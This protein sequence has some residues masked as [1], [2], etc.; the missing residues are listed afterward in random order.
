MHAL[1]GSQEFYRLLDLYSLETYLFEKVSTQFSES[2]TMSSYD[3]F[4]IVIWKSNRAK[5]KIKN[6]LSAIGKTVDELMRAVGT[7]PEQVTK[8][9]L[10]LATPGIG[11]A[12]A[13]AILTVCYPQEFTVL[14]YRAWETLK[15][16]DIPDLP[17]RTPGTASEYVGYC[18]ACK[19][20]AQHIGVSLRDL[21]RV[22]WAKNWEDDLL[23]LTHEVQ[24]SSRISFSRGERARQIMGSGRKFSP[25]RDAVAELVDEREQESL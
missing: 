15:L 22:L 13:S 2:G 11:L 9:D 24:V 3:F 10:L 18:R 5:T 21:D 25:D 23:E 7:T 1:S 16:L 8:V 6:G 20:F 19:V 17:T 12:M 14:D 4:A